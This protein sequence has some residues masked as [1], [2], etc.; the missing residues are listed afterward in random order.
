MWDFKVTPSNSGLRSAL[1]LQVF[2][3][4][5]A[6][7]AQTPATA[8]PNIERASFEFASNRPVGPE[9]LR[10]ARTGLY[11]HYA[12]QRRLRTD[13]RARYDHSHNRIPAD[14]RRIWPT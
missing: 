7:S 3:P 12:V 2:V 4:V 8:Q 6:V 9:E 5:A 1:L 13:A 14:R 10:A 11:R